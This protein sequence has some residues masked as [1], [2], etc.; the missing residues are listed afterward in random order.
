M[1]L[2][3][4]DPGFDKVGF[5]VYASDHPSRITLITSGLIKTRTG[6]VLLARLKDIHTVLEK[7]IRTHGVD[8]MVMEQIF[9]FKN[10]KTVIAVA[11]AQGSIMSLCVPHR[12][13][14]SF[15]TPLQIKQAVTGDGRA[16]KRSVWKMLLLQLGSSLTVKDDDESDAI[17]CGY[18]YCLL[19][20]RHG[21]VS[22][23]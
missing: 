12:L 7:V 9:F 10:A 18:A 8:T 2:L 16:D 14:F 1:I 20:P 5:A 15:L 23:R 6:D 11:Q 17:A 19:A 13:D 4:I 22:M 3:S 21:G